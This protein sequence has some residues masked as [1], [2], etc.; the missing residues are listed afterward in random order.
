VE[1]QAK[2]KVIWWWNYWAK[3]WENKYYTLLKVENPNKKVWILKKEERKIVWIDIE[4]KWYYI[5]KLEDINNEYIINYDKGKKE[6]IYYVWKEVS[7]RNEMWLKDWLV[8]N[9]V[10]TD[11][12]W[13]A[14]KTAGNAAVNTVVWVWEKMGEISDKQR[15]IYYG[16]R[17]FVIWWLIEEEKQTYQ[18]WLQDALLES[19][20]YVIAAWIAGKWFELFIK[21]FGEWLLW[22]FGKKIA[23]KF[24]AKFIPIL[25]WT[26]LAA[27]IYD[28]IKND[29]EVYRRCQTDGWIFEWK[30]QAYWC[31][32][33]TVDGMLTIAG[34]G[35]VW[36][37]GIGVFKRMTLIKELENSWVKFT[38]EAIKDIKK[39]RWWQIFWLEQWD[40]RRWYYH[41]FEQVRNWWL[42]RYEEMIKWWVVS[43]KQELIDL[44]F[45]VI[46][47]GEKKL[48][49]GWYEFSMVVKWKK[50]IVATWTNWFIVSTTI[51]KK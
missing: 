2:L 26:L 32:R 21:K 20:W 3:K 12:V 16:R 28:L 22:K 34:V 39:L 40:D 46:N 17:Y 30:P 51:V 14:L 49:N 5:V 45:K 13:W 31:G 15:M 10:F 9:N 36:V 25:W 4:K 18:E 7:D 27:A 44:M 38:K 8:I 48:K 35:V 24:A 42:T 19:L 47:K 50:V 23:W 1:E 43:S 41:I 6:V 11:W 33:L 37:K 29:Y